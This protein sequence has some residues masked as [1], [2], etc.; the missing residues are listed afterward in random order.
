MGLLQTMTSA[1]HARDPCPDIPESFVDPTR[2]VKLAR[3]L[4]KQAL[5]S[6]DAVQETPQPELGVETLAENRRVYEAPEVQEKRVVASRVRWP[7]FGPIL[8]TA[9]WQWGFFG[10][11]RK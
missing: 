5:P 4:K 10:A 3:E 11:Q 2:I 1:V 6:E 7:N 9:A 8:A